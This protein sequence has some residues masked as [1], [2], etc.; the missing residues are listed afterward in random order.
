M[1]MIIRMA[2]DQMNGKTE[3]LKNK[4]SFDSYFFFI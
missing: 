4:S 1:A 2:E 3:K